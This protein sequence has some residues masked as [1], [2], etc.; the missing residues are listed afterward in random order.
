MGKTSGLAL[1]KIDCSLSVSWT[2]TGF[3]FIAVELPSDELEIMKGSDFRDQYEVL[4]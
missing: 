3:G 2:A 1:S 4:P